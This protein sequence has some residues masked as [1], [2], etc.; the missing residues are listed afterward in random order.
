M[1]KRLIAI[2][3]VFIGA[4]I[5]WLILGGTLAQRTDESYAGQRDRLR[6]QWGAAQVQTA[7]QV[8]VPVPHSKEVVTVPIR[9]SRV[10]VGL[11]LEQ[12][13]KG[14]PSGNGWS[15]TWKCGNLITGNV[16]GMMVPYPMQP[17]PLAQ[18]ITFWA[19]VALLFY[20]FVMLLITTLR[21]VDLHPMNYFFLAAAFFAFHLLFA[22]VVGW[23]FA[24]VESGLTITLG[25]IA[26]LFVA[27]QTTGR[28]D[29][30]QRF[31]SRPASG[32]R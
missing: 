20:L 9:S 12:R 25:A 18:R 19:P 21:G 16:I 17:G 11:Q 30:S 3:V 28:I 1:L 24:A 14:L 13:R 5:A 31:S 6:A 29:W 7:P 26:T 8:W 4:S 15:L 32:S 23:R 27:M 2:A 10:K 22:Y